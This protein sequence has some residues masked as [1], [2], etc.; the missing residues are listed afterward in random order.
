MWSTIEWCQ[1]KLIE[2]EGNVAIVHVL[3]SAMSHL[4]SSRSVIV[5]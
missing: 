2:N 1:D 4:I 5:M 3:I